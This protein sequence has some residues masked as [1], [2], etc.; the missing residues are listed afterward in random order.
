MAFGYPE[1]PERVVLPG[2]VSQSPDRECYQTELSA[3]YL[4]TS[5]TYAGGVLGG[6]VVMRQAR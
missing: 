5:M 1:G 3:T 2:V 4:Q 6:P